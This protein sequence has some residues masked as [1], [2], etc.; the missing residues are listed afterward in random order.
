MPDWV[1]HGECNHCGDC[2][3]NLLA[4]A[5][6]I[7]VEHLA[8]PAVQQEDYFHVRQ[9]P[10]VQLDGKNYRQYSGN[11]INPCQYHRESQC[12]V[13]ETRPGWCR[14]FPTRPDQIKEML[15]SYWFQR[16]EEIAGGQGAPPEIISR[17][18]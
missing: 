18:G 5:I 17:Y 10:L 7:P 8:V 1:R 15:C 13:Y 16:G 12:I 2:C 9:I 14:D 11:L 3:A 4:G 6:L